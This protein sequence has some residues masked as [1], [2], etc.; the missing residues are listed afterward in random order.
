MLK[1]VKAMLGGA[2]KGKYNGS[3]KAMPP[4]LQAYLHHTGQA[5]WSERRYDSFA[6]EGYQTNV[7][8]H[9]AIA[10]IA[11]AASSVNFKLFDKDATGQKRE[12]KQHPL[13]ALIEQPSV[14]HHKASFVEA[15]VT[16]RLIS[17]NGYILAVGPDDEAPKELHLLRPDRM[18]IIAGR[19]GYPAAYRHQ[20]GAVKSDYPVHPVTGKSRIL[21]LKAFHPLND[22]Y[23]LSPMEAASHSIDMH[24][25][26]SN[27]NQALLQNSA[28]PSGALGV[29][30]A[31]AGVGGQLSEDQYWRIK[32]QID[33]QFSG[34]S[35][36]GRPLLLEGGLE[37]KEMSLSP[38]EMDYL[39]A[40][41]SAARDIALAFGVPPQMLGI[42]GDN[43][44]ANL[45][46]ARLSLWEQ[47][48]LPL[49]QN[50]IDGL[51]GWLSPLY[52]GNLLL[53]YDQ[54]AISALSLR[55]E[56]MWQRVGE[57]DFLSD[58]EKRQLVGIGVGD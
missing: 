7:I 27:W 33:E 9:R 47:T 15:L 48:V 4:A 39:E 38:R 1:K 34:Y 17:G 56:K 55:R 53:E 8:A 13:L 18:T 3:Q 5:V 50:V 28:R 16:Y 19:N 43:T 54:D 40:R 52:P 45:A 30:N 42:P 25:N 44:Y 37:W 57:A 32:N 23:G 46:E 6:S 2:D 51:N 41:H 10:M 12:I 26:S 36:A 24:N 14:A 22:Y 20:C 29:K 11:S 31:E 35:N 21:H 49:M 58:E